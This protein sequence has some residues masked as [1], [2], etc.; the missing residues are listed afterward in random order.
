MCSKII[1]RAAGRHIPQ[2][3]FK[4]SL[5][6]LPT[7]ALKLTKERDKLQRSKPGDPKIT[8]LNRR[9]DWAIQDHKRRKWHEFHESVEHRGNSSKS[10]P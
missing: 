2:G 10:P 6:Y 8:E 4:D 3:S 9:I 1:T 5:P 7:E